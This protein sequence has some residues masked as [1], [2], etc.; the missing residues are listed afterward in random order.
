LPGVDFLFQVTSD[1]NEV[2][3]REWRQIVR[4]KTWRHSWRWAGED[5]ASCGRG[6]D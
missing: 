1:V 5:S 3:F 2:F 4:S 6:G